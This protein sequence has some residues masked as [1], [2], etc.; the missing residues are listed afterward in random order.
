MTGVTKDPTWIAKYTRHL[1]CQQL[2][3]IGQQ[4]HCKL[5]KRFQLITNLLKPFHASSSTLQFPAILL[6]QR[7][8]YRNEFT[9]LWKKMPFGAAHILPPWWQR[10]L[11]GRHCSGLVAW[12]NS[13]FW[14]LDRILNIHFSELR[15]IPEKA[16]CASNHISVPQLYSD[17]RSL[18]ATFAAMYLPATSTDTMGKMALS[19]IISDVHSSPQIPMRTALWTRSSPLENKALL[20][21]L[22]LT[23]V[24]LLVRE[25]TAS[26]SALYS[27]IKPPIPPSHPPLC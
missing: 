1:W 26:Q 6:S 14:V 8:Y 13:W 7:L 10:I 4:D 22:H 20:S 16:H 2:L 23:I 27:S 11:L 17:S 19:A 25:P 3:I 21:A 12:S 18:I 15:S 5:T 24:P 9:P